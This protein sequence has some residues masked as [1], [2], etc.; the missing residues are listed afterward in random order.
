[1]V[2]LRTI[3]LI[4]AAL[5]VCGYASGTQYAPNEI[6]VKYKTGG[7]PLMRKIVTGG[8]TVS[9]MKEI[10][11]ERIRVS[12]MTPERAIQ[13][14][15]A[16]HNVVYAERNPLRQL[17]YVP[18]DPRLGEQYG[19]DRVQARAAWDI[20]KGSSSTIMCVIDTGVRLDH[21]EFV[22]RIAPGC[23]DW[24]DNDGD[25]TDDTGS[26]H[27][28][29]TSGIAVAATDNGKGVASVCFNG[30]LLHMKIFP[31]AYA[32]TSASAMIDAANKGARVISMS[33]GSSA[34]SQVEQDAVNYAWGKGVILFAAA[35][36]NGDTVKH[37]PAALDNVIAVA[38]TN[39]A[40]QRADFSTYGD[41]VHIAAPGENILSTFFGS[42]TDYVY[43]SGTSMACP[44][45]ASV[46][47]LMIGR[48]PSL[49][50]QEVRD[51][52]FSTCDYVGDFVIHGRVNAYS[53]IQQVSQP[54]PYDGTPVSAQVAVVGG[55]SEGTQL[56][57]YG[58]LAAAG[59]AVK[60]VDGM[61]YNVKSV[62]R[63]RLGATAGV[64]T[65][66]YVAPDAAD[67]LTATIN[68]SAKSADRSSALVFL[69]NN[70][71]GSWDQFGSMSMSSQLK[72]SS[73]SIPL[74]ALPH[75]LNGSNMI[76]I[77]VRNV[78]SVRM[79]TQAYTLSIDQLN[80]SGT[81]KSSI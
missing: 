6:L 53:C 21:E 50:N 72:A 61:M 40:D 55:V 71:T 64:D 26:G 52:I 81:S 1:M 62:S 68:I 31:N 79:G 41:W 43:E 11:V 74:S 78:L 46:A 47:G 80:V 4:L 17:D 42:S 2:K 14:F 67:L 38:A 22:G 7:V 59:A 57:S 60:S 70:S 32:S 15:R 58:S 39:S 29:H 27:G 20:S 16:D 9:T 45:A 19:M 13:V 10:K 66:V 12:G 34:P 48:N 18:N 56:G 54:L 77:M 49:T 51:I 63:N 8:T 30:Q 28:T 35:G 5:P 37:Y 69:Y 76:R 25:V 33:Y 36:N 65:Y 3:A 44:F 73:F 24:S 23:Y 75:Y